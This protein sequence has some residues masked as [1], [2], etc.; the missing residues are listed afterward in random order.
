[1]DF[2]DCVQKWLQRVGPHLHPVEEL[3]MI[4]RYL[5]PRAGPQGQSYQMTDGKNPHCEVC[6]HFQFLAYSAPRASMLYYI[7]NGGTDMGFL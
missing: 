3:D 7:A 2:C 4:R 5:E 1:M 6:C